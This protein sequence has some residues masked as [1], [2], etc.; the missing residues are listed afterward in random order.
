MLFFVAFFF[1]VVF[2]AFSFAF[3]FSSSSASLRSVEVCTA[4]IFSRLVYVGML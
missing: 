2:A 1:G 4:F 3:L